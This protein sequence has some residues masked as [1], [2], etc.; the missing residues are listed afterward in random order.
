MAAK[1][2][3]RTVQRTTVRRVSSGTGGGPSPAESGG[4]PKF[5]GWQ[6]GVAGGVAV[7]G[8]YAFFI[9]KPDAVAKSSV[10]TNQTKNPKQSQDK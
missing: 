5:P 2:G 9:A 6:I 1:P 10:P 3:L 4:A 7:A 8:L